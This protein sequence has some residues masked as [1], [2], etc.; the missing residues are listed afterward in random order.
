MPAGDITKFNQFKVD[1]GNKRHD[2]DSDQWKAAFIDSTLAPL[3]TNA[4]PAWGGGGTTN[5]STNEVSAGGN[6]TAG[7]IVL[8][9]A[10]F[11]DGGATAPWRFGKIAI[12]SHASNPT[13]CR[14]LILYNNSDAIK[15]CVM[16]MD[17]GA[18]LDLTTGPFEF[19]FSSVD[20]VGAIA[21]FT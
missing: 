7:G 20:G 21:N 19:R 13:N 15:R 4:V 8:T 6:Y 18:V 1:L 17:L 9:S 2:L 16:F 14:W 5:L 3:A 12:A 10:D 11:I